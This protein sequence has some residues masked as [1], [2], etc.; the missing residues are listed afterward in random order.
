M[1]LARV[2]QECRGINM[3]RN[4]SCR[5]R[6]RGLSRRLLRFFLWPAFAL[7]LGAVAF[8]GVTASIS[9][10]VRDASGAAIAGATVTA[11]NTDTGIAQNEKTNSAGFYS[12]PS[13]PPGRYEVGVQEA[14]F[15][16]YRKIGLVLDVNAALV[17]DVNLQVGEVKEVIQVQS[18][19][20]HV[21]TA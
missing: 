7:L 14:G 3:R 10:T 19:A 6:R 17:A 1:Q 16:S 12:F 13:L 4:C 21:E 20:V 11:T 5:A 15:K 2:T 8:A 18:N 9:G